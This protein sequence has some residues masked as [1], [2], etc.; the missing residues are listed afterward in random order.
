MGFKRDI[1]AKYACLL[2]NYFALIGGKPEARHYD[3]GSFQPLK[4]CHIN[5]KKKRKRHTTKVVV[6]FFLSSHDIK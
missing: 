6:K 1:Y 4:E 2:K 3:D 5:L